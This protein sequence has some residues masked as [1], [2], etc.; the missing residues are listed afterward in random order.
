MSSIR[1]HLRA[2]AATV[3]ASTLLLAS[4]AGPALAAPGEGAATTSM[5][6]IEVTLDG[7]PLVT[8][9]DGGTVATTVGAPAA[10]ATLTGVRTP[11]GSFGGVRA[12][13]DGDTSTQSVVVDETVGGA[14]VSVVPLTATARATATGAVATLS[15][16]GADAVASLEG[17]LGAVALRVDGLGA[18]STVGGSSSAAVQTLQVSGLTV[19]LADLVPALANLPLG[20]VLALLDTLGLLA[21]GS[22][23]L[24]AAVAALDEAVAALEAGLAPIEADAAAILALVAASELPALATFDAALEELLGRTLDLGNLLQL[25]QFV[26]DVQ[27]LLSDMPAGL[28]APAA[29]TGIDPDGSLLALAA[30]VPDCLTA[31]AALDV[32]VDDAAAAA[33]ALISGPLDALHGAI[34]AGDP[35]LQSLVDAVTAAVAPLAAVLDELAALLADA[36]GTELVAVDGLTVGPVAVAGQTIDDT[37]ASVACSGE[38]R[39]LGSDL[40]GGTCDTTAAAIAELNGLVAGAVGTV[41]DILDTLPLADVVDLS[42]LDLDLLADSTDATVCPGGAAYARTCSVDGVQQAT[43]GMEVLRLTVPSIV[44]DPAAASNGLLELGAPDV[45]GV[46]Q[47]LIGDVESAVTGLLGDGSVGTPAGQFTVPTTLTDA[48][49]QLV[50]PSLLDPVETAVAALD[51]AVGG[52]ELPSLGE[53][54]LV[55]ATPSLGVVVDPTSTATF[56]AAGGITPAPGDDDGGSPTAGAPGEDLPTTG[57]GLAL[58]G[59]AALGA[60]GALTRR[61]RA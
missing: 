47:G 50:A 33:F 60:A 24:D 43:A 42:G 51:A 16:V 3:A 1:V 57:G 54:G 10:L 19:T 41:T 49:A 21:G 31:L 46:L 18:T 56:T 26:S 32:A 5:T 9:L 34:V 15:G 35:S 44:L 61:R 17:L 37:S 6:A 22:A 2:R 52:L 58:L 27:A 39:V 59:L 25:Q 45:V 55:L 20:N 14:T 29:C 48:V 8:V 11:A 23:E 36:G 13:H 38:V 28:T 7:V 53:E 30:A 4:V 40:L 12:D